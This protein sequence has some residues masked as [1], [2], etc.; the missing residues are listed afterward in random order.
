M[1]KVLAVHEFKEEYLDL[2]LEDYILTFDGGLLSQFSYIKE[3][4]KLNTDK[5]FFV[6]TG[7]FDNQNLGIH[8]TLDNLYE[9]KSMR[10]FEIG[11]CGHDYLDFRNSNDNIVNKLLRLRR[12]TEEMQN[13][14]SKKLRIR[15]SKFCFPYNV[16]VFGYR[17]ILVKYGYS[18]FFG[19]ERFDIEDL[20]TKIN[21]KLGQCS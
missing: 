3:L 7:I 21:M 19:K 10:D 16:D 6:P 13:F 15:P 2:P 5:I 1:K 12:D 18:E 8:L 14:F 9:L 17:R 11:G 20:I 4:E